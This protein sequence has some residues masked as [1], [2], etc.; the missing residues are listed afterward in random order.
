MTDF[1]QLRHELRLKKEADQQ[2]I[3]EKERE[4]CLLEEVEKLK[5]SASNETPGVLA[6]MKR[7]RAKARDSAAKYH[8]ALEDRITSRERLKDLWGAILPLTDPRKRVGN[9]SDSLPI[10]MFPLRLETRFKKVQIRENS[11][12]NEL[13]IRIYPDDCLVDT[14]EEDL[15]EIERKN[16]RCY[17]AFHWAA[18]GDEEMERLTWKDLVTSHG[19]GRSGWI[20]NAYQPL[21]QADRPPVPAP[22]NEFYLTIPAQENEPLGTDAVTVADFWKDVFLKNENILNASELA[23]QYPPANLKETAP[24]GANVNVVF[25]RFPAFGM[26]NSKPFAWSETPKAKLLPERFVFL[27]YNTVDAELTLVKEAIT[28]RTVQAPLSVGPSPTASEKEQF[29]E[30]EDGD[31]IVPE[32]MRWMTDFDTALEKGMAFRIP[33]DDNL[34]KNGF[35]RVIVTGL[36]L[37]SSPTEAKEELEELLKHHLFGRSGFSIVPQ[38]TPTNNTDDGPSG[39]SRTDDPDESFLVFVK[40]K[41]LFEPTED[42]ELKTDG[43]RLAEWLDIDLELLQ[44][45]PNADQTDQAEA[46]AM[47]VALWPATMGYWMQKMMDPVFRE[48]S[49]V[50]DTRN[51]FTQYVSGR[52][53][54]PAIRIGKQPYGLIQACAYRNI[55]WLHHSPAITSAV[56]YADPFIP[57]LYSLL[58]HLDSYWKNMAEQVPYVGKATDDPQQQL[59]NIVGLHPSSAEYYT[60]LGHSR[61][62]LHNYYSFTGLLTTDIFASMGTDIVA[63]AKTLLTFLGY[64]GKIE[65]KIFEKYYRNGQNKIRGPIVDDR[66]LSEKELIRTYSESGKNYIGWLIEA[67]GDYEA[68][69]LPQSGLD[70]RPSALLYLL[71]RHALLEAY[72]NAGHKARFDAKVTDLATYQTALAIEP[73]FIHVEVAN[74]ESESRFTHLLAVE[75]EVSEIQVPLAQYLGMAIREEVPELSATQEL[76]QMKKALDLLENVPT[77][78]LERLLSEHVD[79]CTY[80]H[81]AWMQ[82]ILHYQLQRMRSAKTEDEGK[83]LYLGAFAWLENLKPEGKILEPVDLPEDLAKI[84]QQE[85][86]SELTSDTANYGYVHAPSLN[87]AVTAAVLRNGYISDAIPTQPDLLAVNLSSKRVRLALETLEGIRNGQSLSALLGYRFERK[88][89]DEDPAMFVFSYQL[90]KSFPLVANKLESTKDTLEEA[91]EAIAARNVVDGYSLLKKALGDDGTLDFSFLTPTLKDPVPN[92]SQRAFIEETIKDLLDIHDALSDIGISE[93]VHQIVQG[94][95]DRASSTLDAYSKATFPQMPD[96]VVTPRSGLTLTHRVAIQLNGA[97]AQN[98]AHTPRAKAE[99]AI[100]EWLESMLPALD[101]TAIVYTYTNPGEPAPEAETDQVTLKELGFQPLDLIYLSDF[102]SGQAMGVLEERIFQFIFNKPEVHANASLKI[103]F[104]S[105]INNASAK[106]SFF[107]IAPLLRSLRS[108]VLTSRPLRPNDPVPPS[109]TSNDQEPV[110]ALEKIRIEGVLPDI[111]PLNSIVT[112][113]ESSLP[114]I[115]QQLSEFVGEFSK[116]SLYGITAAGFGFVYNSRQ[117]IYNDILQKLEK[118]LERWDKRQ[119]DFE[120]IMTTD[121]PAA[122]SDEESFKLLRKVEALVSTTFATAEPGMIPPFQAA[123]TLKG[124]NFNNKKLAL[125]NIL[126]IPPSR[127]HLLV[128]DLQSQLPLTDFDATDFNLKKED[129]SIARFQKEMLEKAKALKLELQSR[130]DRANEKLDI[131]DE[132][133]TTPKKKMEALQSAGNVLFGEEFVMV[134]YFQLPEH[135]GLEWQNSLGEQTELLDFQKTTDMFPVDTWFHG[136]ARVREKMHHLENAYMLA[137]AFGRTPSDLIPTQFPFRKWVPDPESA[138]TVEKAEPWLALEYPSNFKP[139][140]EKLLFTAAYFQNFNRSTRQCGLLLDEWT[141]V[142]P[143][144]EETTGL[145]FHYDRPNSESPQA[146]LLVTASQENGEWDWDDLVAA[147]HQTLDLAKQRAV[148]PFQ[149]EN[150]VLGVFSPATVFPVTPWAINPSLNLNLANLVLANI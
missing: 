82:G 31:L 119:D 79:C 18:A 143:T 39:F 114:D 67:M 94:N 11:F 35:E 44:Q 99:P 93:S 14:F 145:T 136:T 8:A 83:G 43:Q 84:F 30:T 128:T 111:S 97:A 120:Q 124:E 41:K 134:Q 47:N 107:E 17:W 15:T 6:E 117:E 139:D 103:E 36:R 48:N 106:A 115:D 32:E 5:R 126:K 16:A 22:P 109:E 54:C 116:I 72:G 62:F 3:R 108:I 113:W 42:T 71:L 55:E 118:Y 89:H 19:S 24:D 92:T 23:K 121:L 38:G 65:P 146:W 49:N 125:E 90:R 132:A 148:E 40:E 66:P 56:S 104:T 53:H 127:L 112:A 37:G 63:A 59:L 76:N 80:R 26:E 144:Q 34:A 140:E 69:L 137:E 33:L 73:E 77:A 13:W 129:A 110:S 86:D 9:W 21:N 75:P 130:L 142:V 91:Q 88:L 123:V 100:N 2:A 85:G 4:R 81:D 29:V 138:P 60:R 61:S 133:T 12:K 68:K 10:L 149:V 1:A 135:Q 141:E 25:I 78:R 51:F 70:E 131:H 45:T 28:Q 27:G 150:T 98:P 64:D 95:Y 7:L 101:E 58:M 74:E 20:I 87:Q 57:K 96:V 46:K 122:T 102:D 147:M 105:P 50:I 52:G